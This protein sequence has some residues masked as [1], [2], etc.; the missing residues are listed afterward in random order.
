MII[1]CSNYFTTFI[2]L[3]ILFVQYQA[4]DEGEGS[5]DNE[6]LNLIKRDDSSINLAKREAIIGSIVEISETENLKKRAAKKSEKSTKKVSKEKAKKK[7]TKKPSSKKPKKKKP[8]KYDKM[9]NKIIN[10]INT[11]RKKYQAQKLTVDKTLATVAQNYVDRYAGKSVKE[12][13]VKLSK[14]TSVGTLVYR[15]KYN[16]PYIPFAVWTLGAPFIDFSNP[17]RFPAGLEFTQL[18]WA[19]TKKIGCGISYRSAS[20]E[21]IT[22]CLLSPKGNIEGKFKKNVLKPKY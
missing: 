8:S 3:S 5:G 4:L 13:D 16:H 7:T 6:S 2:I 1:F 10:T 19:S 12:S 9:K 20:K 22:M 17:E 15:N 21:V 11:I 14:N 18:I